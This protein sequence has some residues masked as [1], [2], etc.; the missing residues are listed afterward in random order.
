MKLTSLRPIVALV[1]GLILTLPFSARSAEF[2]RLYVDTWRYNNTGV[3]QG[4]A[5][6]APNFDDTG[7][8]ADLSEF[9]FGDGDEFTTLQ[10]N[11]NGV[12]LNTAYFRSTFN[13]ANPATYSNLSLYLLRDDGAVVYLNGV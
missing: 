1:T 13:V 3:D 7:W 5:W 2:L 8:P 6:R 12:P 10:S 9:G 11:P 4:T